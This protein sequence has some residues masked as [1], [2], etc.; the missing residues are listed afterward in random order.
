MANVRLR[1]C[2]WLG[3]GWTTLQGFKK[4]KTIEGP[5]VEVGCKDRGQAV[6]GTHPGWTEKM[7]W[8]DRG[9]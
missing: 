9:A 5:W 3:V 4:I 2:R 6:L 1:P 8:P 7:V